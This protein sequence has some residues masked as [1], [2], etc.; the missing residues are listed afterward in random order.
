MAEDEIIKHTKKAYKA[1]RDPEKDWM[2]KAKEILLEVLIIVFAVSVSIWLHNWSEDVKDQKEEKEFLK[3]LK[4]DIAADL[5]EM[6]SDRA[7]L[8]RGYN[9][10]L[11]FKKIG[12]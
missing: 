1:F 2:H 7:S 12:A 5:K 9:A 10:I 8:L 11:Y 6:S 3:G 4:G